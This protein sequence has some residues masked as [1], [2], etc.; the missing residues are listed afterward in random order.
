MKL[1]RVPDKTARPLAFWLAMEEWIAANMP[2]DS[3]EEYFFVWQPAGKTVII[4]RHQML[5]REVNVDFCHGN[6]IDIV[7]RKSGG[8]AVYSDG[9]NLMMSYITARK[10]AV[11]N[12]FS[13]YTSMVVKSL[14]A[15]GLDAS[16]NSRNDIMISGLK[17]SG[18]SYYRAAKG[19]SIVHGTMLWGFDGE[20]MS[21]ALTPSAA[22]LKSHGVESVRSR[23]TSV[24]EHL[25]GLDIDRFREHLISTIPDGGESIYL[26][27]RQVDEI[28]RISREVYT[29]TWL[30]GKS[31]AGELETSGRVNGVGQM[32]VFLKIVNGE[33]KDAD[34]RGDFLETADASA[35]LKTALKGRK[36]SR[37]KIAGAVDEI[38]LPALIPNLTRE[39]FV[40]LIF[41]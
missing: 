26:T 27:D 36:F 23:V 14:K 8:G 9:N 40:N 37:D 6:G 41:N 11:E 13:H 4:G 30:E 20:M 3:G 10:N 19:I 2:A 33:I 31:P 15:L 34:L 28:E 38:N 25:P 24:S 17:V 32:S 16:D 12:T 21:K 35:A 29:R 39:G 1:V 18:N 22:K 5:E 7:R